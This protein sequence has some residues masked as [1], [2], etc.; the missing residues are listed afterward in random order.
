MSASSQIF[1]GD[2][3][4]A[5][6]TAGN[7]TGADWSSIC[8]LLGFGSA[9][10][11]HPTDG[12][13]ERETVVPHSVLPPGN[14]AA[15]AIPIP[16]AGFAGSIGEIIDFEL[17]RKPAPPQS[18]SAGAASPVPRASRSLPLKSLFEPLWERGILVE[19]AG[20]PCR[21]GSLIVLE[22]VAQLARG[23][24]VRDL[25]RERIQSVSKGC[26]ILIDT[27]VGMQPFAR[28]CRQVV[29]SIRRAVGN[30][31]ARTFTFV[32]CP[33]KGVV[34]EGYEDVG[35]RAP[36]NGAVV[37]AISDLIRGG[38]RSALR[39][40]EPEDWLSVAKAIHDAGSLLIVLNPYAQTRWPSALSSIVP[41]I[42]WDQSTRAATVRRTRRQILG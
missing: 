20:V 4:W 22:A 33:A 19:I 38:P 26:H 24:A 18:I 40:A 31:K 25:P 5:L 6:L 27:G 36:Q 34:T 2:L 16:E 3:A 37:V 12:K 8:S 21:E 39:E 17:D 29:E 15:T 35:Y 30:D 32:D 28:D 23:E 1:L 42:Y 7:P 41:I 13:F 10:A 14:T 9:P 11:I